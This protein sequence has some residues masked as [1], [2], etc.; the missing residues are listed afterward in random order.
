MA[1]K[2]TLYHGEFAGMGP[3]NIKVVGEPRASKF[4]KQ[5]V[6]PF[7]VVLSI[8][9][10]ERHYQPENDTCL[11]FFRG[12]GG[13]EITVVAEGSREEARITFVGQKAS[14]LPSKQAAAKPQGAPPPHDAPP[15]KRVPSAPQRTP[16]QAVHD[17]KVFVGQNMT[18][19]KIAIRGVLI[20]N[21]Q[22]AEE[23]GVP[24]PDALITSVYNT[25]LY[26]SE[27]AGVINGLPPKLDLSFTNPPTK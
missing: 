1:E 10:A 24:M 18:L 15:P 13:Q 2:K 16:E 22:F 11:E 3:V 23:V 20:L 17:A 9:G 6:P 21:Q 25:L 4:K 19:A 26:G 14:S 27:R 12:K 5:G 7:Y 8:N